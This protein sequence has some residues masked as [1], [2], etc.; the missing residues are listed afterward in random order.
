MIT[1]KLEVKE[2]TKWTP[3]PW[4]AIQ[5]RSGWHTKVDSERREIGSIFTVWHRDDEHK[6]IAN[7]NARLIASAPDLYAALEGCLAQLLGPAQVYGNG[8]GNDGTKTGLSGEEFNAL[9]KSRIEAARAAL[10][11]A[12]GE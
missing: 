12:R 6:A 8:C 7:A 3:G 1:S 2:R 11:K 10:L 5:E 9:Q 4:T